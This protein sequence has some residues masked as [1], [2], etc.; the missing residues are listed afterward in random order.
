TYYRDSLPAWVRGLNSS[1]LATKWMGKKW[2]RLRKDV[3]YDK[4]AGPDDEPG[5][6][7]G[8]VITRTFPHLLDGGPTKSKSLYLAALGTS[9]FGNDVLLEA[10]RKAID[11]E[12][13][14]QRDQQDFL[15]I[16]FSSND[17]IG[18]AWGPDS[19]EVLDV[20]LRSDL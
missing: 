1:G 7:R 12:K 13:L 3:D 15:S 4:Q 17:L 5:E 20:T 11:A 10:A 19:H 2:E 9:P 8:P 18:H 6:L 14:G 16:S